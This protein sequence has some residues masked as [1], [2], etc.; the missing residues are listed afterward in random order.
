[1][2]EQIEDKKSILGNIVVSY[3]G[4]VIALIII[5]LKILSVIDI[6]WT[7]A[8]LF[9]ITLLIIDFFNFLNN[10]DSKKIESTKERT[11]DDIKFV[12]D[13]LERKID[14]D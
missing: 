11:D 9:S 6:T 5:V 8:I 3:L 13:K 14:G 12:H 10:D 7:I 4:T 2:E 1:M